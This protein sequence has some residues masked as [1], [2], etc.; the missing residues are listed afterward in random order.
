MA[1]IGQHFTPAPVARW[2]CQRVARSGTLDVVDPACG[3]GALLAA[4]RQVMPQSRLL[5]VELDAELVPQTRQALPG[6]RIIQGDALALAQSS[7]LKAASADL[8]L[9]N[10]PYIGEKGHRP[11]FEAAAG[12]GPIWKART[13]PR[14]DY[15]YY[16]LHLG[17]DLLRPGG[18]L[19]ALTTAY[20]PSASGADALRADL[21]A[22]AEIVEWIRFGGKPLFSKA[23]GQHNL[24]V[25]LRRTDAPDTSKTY[26]WSEVRY[27]GQRLTV[28]EQHQG[29]RAPVD[30]AP[31]QP[32][33][34][35]QAQAMALE[36][37]QS[38]PV[39]LGELA[40]D[41]Q[42]VVSGCDR[43][44]KRH[45]K[46][47]GQGVLLERPGF[48]LTGDQVRERG[49]GD[50]P[51]VRPFLEPL[52]RGAT[53]QRL[54][55][56]RAKPALESPEGLVMIYLDGHT[57]PPE[58]LLEHLKPLRPVLERR[59]E[60]R[61]GLRPW[62]ALHWPRRLA[63][64]RRP[65]LI[66]ARRSAHVRFGLDLAGHVVSSDCTF[67]VARPEALVRLWLVLHLPEV[68]RVMR[69]TGKL[70][71]GLLEFYS[72]PLQRLP[73]PWLEQG[74]WPGSVARSM[75]VLEQTV[76]ERGDEDL[77]CKPL[78]DLMGSDM[79]L[80]TGSRIGKL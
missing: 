40:Q 63:D 30:S 74:R 66:T 69:A 79:A 29:L 56:R 16:F 3:P 64:M 37:A 25:I 1:G 57:K 2:L 55:V 44:G 41:R 72:Q 59:R 71:G 31:W 70:K 49:W 62:W 73:L 7:V 43:V 12:L 78:V 15:L 10:P 52:W 61:E 65:K 21:L 46:W 68:E 38:W 54:E 17:L 11:L 58:A 4:C 39:T 27:D 75:A 32:F 76:R 6:A 80:E 48:I 42:G 5:G 8:V 45:L 24:A 60:V 14:M 28:A 20:W 77:L 51:D 47:L 33:V 13:R 19:M 53:T 23:L 50:D 18:T 67:V 22:R 35:P 36:A 9:L 34:H 26:G